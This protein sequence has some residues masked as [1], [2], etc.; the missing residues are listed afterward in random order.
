MR[1]KKM[2]Q[3]IDGILYDTEKA[4]EICEY[5]NYLPTT[6]FRNMRETLF[7]TKKGNWFIAATGGAMTKYR[8]QFGN[9]TSGSSEI[10]PISEERAK[11][12]IEKYGTIEQ[13]KEYFELEEA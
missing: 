8:K 13:Y 10:I 5:W 9:M 11:K 2:N 1:N 12:F 3:I 6:D 7:I 4:E